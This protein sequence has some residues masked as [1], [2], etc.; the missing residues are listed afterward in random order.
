MAGKTTSWTV[1]VAEAK[2]TSSPTPADDCPVC[3]GSGESEFL[4]VH[5]TP[6]G[7]WKESVDW[8]PCEG[9]DGT[10]EF[11]DYARRRMSGL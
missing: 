6:W 10:G 4:V 9:C 1:K 2:V 8:D 5:A 11:L 3:Q 7:S